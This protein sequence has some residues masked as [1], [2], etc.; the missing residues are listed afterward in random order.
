LGHRQLAHVV[1][2]QLQR[3]LAPHAL[4]RVLRER[5]QPVA[6]LAHHQIAL[7]RLDALEATVVVEVGLELLHLGKPLLDQVA[8][9]GAQGVGGELEALAQHAAGGAQ[10][11]ASQCAGS[12][13]CWACRSSTDFSSG[14]KG[15]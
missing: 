14:A 7:R 12:R 1:A 5:A 4:L 3:A 13:C 15:Y 11:E 2:R 10:A 8:V 9:L 6:P